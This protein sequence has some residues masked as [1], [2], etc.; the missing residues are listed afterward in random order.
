LNKNI[1]DEVV[2]FF[3]LLDRNQNGSVDRDELMNTVKK[4]AASRGINFTNPNWKGFF[5]FLMLMEMVKLV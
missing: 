4:I 2:K 3:N 5:G 1:K